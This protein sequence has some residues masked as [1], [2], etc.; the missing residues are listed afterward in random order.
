[1][2]SALFFQSLKKCLADSNKK[3]HIPTDIS[4]FDGN[5]FTKERLDQIISNIQPHIKGVKIYPI[6]VDGNI[7]RSIYVVKIP[8]SS[9]APHMATDHKYYKRNNFQ[10][11]AME[12]YEVRDLFFRADCPE[13]EIDVCE[14]NCI[15]RDKVRYEDYIFEFY[16]GVRNIG[17]KLCSNFKLALICK[18][19]RFSRNFTLIANSPNINSFSNTLLD[20]GREKWTFESKETIFPS[21]SLD[22]SVSFKIPYTHFKRFLDE[23]DFEILLWYDGGPKTYKYNVKED[24][25]SSDE[26]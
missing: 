2:E 15:N 8:R 25:F 7:S 3:K 11:I 22:F 9:I 23:S 6:R 13:L 24:V 14:C 10:S 20:G 12:D 26:V 16:I 21:E 18:P 17:R 5:A 1:M 19:K 4:T